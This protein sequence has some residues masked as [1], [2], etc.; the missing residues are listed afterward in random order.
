[1]GQ[2]CSRQDKQEKDIEY[3]KNELSLIKAGQGSGSSSGISR[4]TSSTIRHSLFEDYRK[5]KADEKTDIDD[6]YSLPMVKR[7]VL[8]IGGHPEEMVKDPEA[9]Y[10][11]HH[12]LDPGLRA[13]RKVQTEFVF[14][15]SPHA[16]LLISCLLRQKIVSRSSNS[17]WKF[18]SPTYVSV[19]HQINIIRPGPQA[20]DMCI[21]LLQRF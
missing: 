20:K 7:R 14:S 2:L 13:G 19:R 5:V 17:V 3:F 15:A 8:A 10:I 6:Q 9:H 12:R 1:M 21:S 18:E 11:H 4:S 16:S